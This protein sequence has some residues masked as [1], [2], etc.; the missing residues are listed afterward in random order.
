MTFESRWL[1]SIVFAAG[2][3]AAF[4]LNEFLP[5]VLH[6]LRRH[7]HAL[8][9]SPVRRGTKSTTQQN[10]AVGH[11]RKIVQGVEGCIGDTPLIKIKSLSDETGC[12]I[13]AK[14]EV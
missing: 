8:D 5:F 13:L 11:S 4:S 1:A 9:A 7:L 3:L 2:G 12:E 10:V 6:G 14:A